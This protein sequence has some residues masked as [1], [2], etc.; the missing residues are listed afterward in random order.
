MRY[1]PHDYQTYAIDYIKTHPIATVFLDMG[2][3]KTSITLTAIN[4]LLFDSF[5]VHKVLVI[6]PLRVARDTWTAEVHKWDH[7]QNLSCSVAV[8][9]EPQRRAAFMRKADIY[10]INR[11]NVQWLVEESGIVFDFDMIVIDELSSFKS[12]NTKRFT[13][14]L[15]VR[16]KVKRIVGL[17]GT[18]ASN[19]LMDLWAEFR[20]LDMGQ[21]LGRFITRYRTDYFQPDK[22]NGQII[23]SYKPLPFAEDAIYNKIG[24]ITISMKATDHLQIPELISSEYTV[25]LSE[26]DQKHYEKLKR[27]LVLSLGDGE[28]TASNA[29]SL[30]GKLSQMAN[31]AIYDD[32]GNTISIHD[33]KLDALEDIIEAA[34]G[35]PVLVAYWFKHDLIRISERLKKLHIPFSRLDDADSIRRWNKGDIPVALIHPASAGHGL[36]LQSGGSTLVWFGLT[37]SL[38]LY[39][40]TVARLWRQGQTSETVVVQHILTKGTIDSRIMKALSQKEHTQTALIDAVKADLTIKTP[41]VGT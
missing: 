25:S 33:R 35:K 41:E 37:W 32:D 36:N 27:E 31:G 19:G 17:T 28:I 9:T 14:M 21:R 12:H 1:A 3:G 39:Q 4:D 34:N 38:E 5:E 16:P 2:L 30:S 18:P 22:R 29:A 23:Y 6:A 24:D 10:I 15:K 11:E 8:G 40:Q 20:I 13:A 7:L 26:E